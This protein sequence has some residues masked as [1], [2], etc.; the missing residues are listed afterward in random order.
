MGAYEIES[1]CKAFEDFDDVVYRSENLVI[2]KYCYD[3]YEYNSYINVLIN[4]L[5]KKRLIFCRNL[6]KKLMKL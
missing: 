3:N 1:M 2:L 5:S 4:P 6:W